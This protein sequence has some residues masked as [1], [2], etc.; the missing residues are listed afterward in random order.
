M[1]SLDR[2]LLLLTGILAAYQVAVG[3]NGLDEVPIIA[4]TIGFGV[5]LVAGLLLIILGFEA[6]DSP[7]VVVVSTVIPL[8]IALG[9][10][11]EHLASFRTSYLVF[12]IVG[13]LA[14]TLTRSIPVPGKI[15]TLVLA[16]VHGIAGLTIFL[17]PPILAANGTMKPTFALVGLGGALIGL[18]GLLLSFL[19]AG[20]PIVPR[21]TI[22][23]ILPSLLLL[24]T[25]CFVAG[26]KF[27]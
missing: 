18:A 24:M 14:V 7:I 22:L 3:V 4:Y 11:W 27:G 15:P 12:A 8:A 23:K 19:K 21:E 6:L 2:I 20:K 16:V 25:V 9:L 26:F 10:V 5:L 17:L 1:T 13:F